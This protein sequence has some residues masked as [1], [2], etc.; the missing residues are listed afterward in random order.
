ME[1]SSEAHPHGKGRSRKKV[2]T[3]RDV[4]FHSAFA[5]LFGGVSQSTQKAVK[6]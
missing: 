2:V 4:R 3:S 5:S 6:A 1:G